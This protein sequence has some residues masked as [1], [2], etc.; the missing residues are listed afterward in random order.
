MSDS[1][2]PHWLYSIR[3]LCPWDSP[4]K[5]TGVGCHFLLQGIFLNQDW[6]WVF[7]VSCIGRQILYQW[8]SWEAHIKIWNFIRNFPFKRRKMGSQIATKDL[9]YLSSNKWTS[10]DPKIKV[11]IVPVDHYLNILVFCFVLFCF[12]LI[13]KKAH[14][15]NDRNTKQ[16]DR[17]NHDFSSLWD[18]DNRE[19]RL[20]G[21]LKNYTHREKLISKKVGLS[22]CLTILLNRLNNDMGVMQQRIP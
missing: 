22:C 2:R 21:L 7:C 16:L 19:N 12:V 18:S 10:K 9:N 11:I 8:A 3:L 1:L 4:S 5:T 6:T 14:I 20:K 17:T 13:E 15:L